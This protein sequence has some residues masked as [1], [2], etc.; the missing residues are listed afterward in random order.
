MIALD[1]RGVY[2]QRGLE[3]L[4]HDGGSGLEAVLSS[5]SIPIYPSNAASSTNCAIWHQAIVPP[6]QR[7]RAERRTFKADLMR[8][9]RPIFNVPSLQQARTLAT[10]FCAQ[11]QQSQPKLVACLCQDWVADFA[12]CR[13]LA[14]FP[15]W[16]RRYLR[17][18]S[19]LERL[20]RSS[21]R[22]FRVAGDFHS[23]AG[24]RVA[25]TR[26]LAPLRLT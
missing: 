9:L 6:E 26:V 3:L 21:R 12:F 19:L 23:A 16:Q 11:F 4:I 18:T 8:Q 5:R 1:T 17:T 22:L 25:V 24:L 13:V 14:H 7:S 2:R 10:V 20:N 15:T